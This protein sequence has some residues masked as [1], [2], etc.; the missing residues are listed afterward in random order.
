MGKLYD[1]IKEDIEKLNEYRE[2]EVKDF[3]KSKTYPVLLEAEKHR[4][5]VNE[6]LSSTSL[7]LRTKLGNDKYEKIMDKFQNSRKDIIINSINYSYEYKMNPILDY[8]TLLDHVENSISKEDVDDI[9][10]GYDEKKDF[11]KPLKKPL[12]PYINDILSDINNM[13]K[14]PD[15]EKNVAIK[16]LNYIKDEIV[17]KE[18]NN[19]EHVIDMVANKRSSIADGKLEEWALKNNMDPVKVGAYDGKH[20]H[21]IDISNATKEENELFKPV[22]SMKQN[23]SE[24]F[25]NKIVNLDNYLK[26]KSVLVGAQA[27]ESSFKE[28]AFLSYFDSAMNIN[29][30]IDNQLKLDNEKEKIENLFR[31][32]AEANKLQRIS[33][34][35]DEIL[36]YIKE[37]FDINKVSLNGN[38]YSG[39][40]TNFNGNIA[41]FKPTLPEKWDNENAPYGVI[42]NGYVQFKAMVKNASSTVEDMIN[43]P[44]GEFISGAKKYLDNVTDEFSIKAGDASL[45]KR[46]ANTLFNAEKI[47]PS[48]SGY[49]RG[50]RGLE[51]L[52]N[53]CEE[54]EKNYDDITAMSIAVTYANKFS[55]SGR[56]LFGSGIDFDMDS[57]KN[58]F[59]F[60]NDIDNLYTVTKNYPFTLDAKGVIAKNY[61]AQIK[62][63]VDLDPVSE[64][65]NVLE[66][67]KD[68]YNEQKRLFAENP[69]NDISINPGAILLAGKEYFKDYLLK[70]NINPLDIA[71][72]KDRKEVLDFLK[73]PFE[74]FKNK[75]ARNNDFFSDQHHK[76]F[77][78]FNNFEYSLKECSQN[79]YEENVNYFNN[80]IVE[81]IKNTSNANKTID[82]IFDAN[83][84]G[85]FE[86]RIGTTSKEYNAFKAAVESAL[87]NY[88]SS[89]GDFTMAKY[90]AQKYINHKLPEGVDEN[91]LKP[92]EKRRVDFCKSIIKTCNEMDNHNKRIEAQKVLEAERRQKERESSQYK[93]RLDRYKS[94]VEEHKNA[95]EY[96]YLK[97]DKFIENKE[98]NDNNKKVDFEKQLEKDSNLND[99]IINNNFDFKDE[100]QIQDLDILN[101]T[102]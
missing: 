60:G 40:K 18:N 29:K 13:K 83:K 32:S 24:K 57:L 11:I 87:D 28:Y 22:L 45:G 48:T 30:L 69:K 84:G 79:I 101:N 78:N 102:K 12:E 81:N 43:D 86:R 17:V 70:N 65:R 62:S 59:A 92:N 21:V 38:I 4:Y 64:C 19:V 77:K 97:N 16:Y 8:E 34:E 91:N 5:R 96:S 27:G 56:E 55:F 90:F 42:L 46:I 67:C 54:N 26:D 15:D 95:K 20:E 98:L 35:Y 51:F 23:F 61:D 49:I 31:I 88:S 7:I 36:D 82:E 75:Y 41:T 85:Y 9:I 63:K 94:I 68:Y 33:K 66:I 74:T 50:V 2:L 47:L 76:G 72:D 6:L 80:K 37:S 14:M 99:S 73:E 71:N 3:N 89:Y 1:L 100:N 52:Y 53:Q 10:K 39:R 25:K 44:I 58:L 93:F